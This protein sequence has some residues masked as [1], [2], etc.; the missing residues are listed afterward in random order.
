MAEEKYPTSKTFDALSTRSLAGKREYVRGLEERP[1]EEKLSLLVECLCDE[2]WFMRELSEEALQRCGEKAVPALVPLLAQGL[3][4]TRSSA[5]RVLGRLASR[6]PI[7][8]MLAMAGDSNATVADAA[9][10]A[11]VE[12]ARG[13]GAAALARGLHRLPPE[14]RRARLAELVDRDRALGERLGRLLANEELMQ[15]EF[16]EPPADD[17]PLVRQVE[18]GV[19]WE[20]LTG[21][22]PPRPREDVRGDGDQRAGS[23]A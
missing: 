19:E 2:S 7:P 5:A 3:W 11:L 15:A 20:V 4:Y 23:G 21:P 9:R 16:P 14:V 17:S 18:E 12:I 1:D 10:T 8:G 6:T 13:G 22:P